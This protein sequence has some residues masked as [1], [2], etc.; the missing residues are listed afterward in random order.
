MGNAGTYLWTPHGKRT[1]DRG[2]QMCLLPCLNR[3]WWAHSPPLRVPLPRA[4]RGSLKPRKPR[5]TSAWGWGTDNRQRS[6]CC[7]WVFIAAFGRNYRSQRVLSI[8]KRS[9]KAIKPDKMI[10]F[11]FIRNSSLACRWRSS[12]AAASR[13]TRPCSSCR[14]WRQRAHA[15][16]NSS[17]D[18]GRGFGAL[19]APIP[20][21]LNDVIC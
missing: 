14:L 20:E 8:V 6:V 15:L 13:G 4:I 2:A 3:R 7:G 12:H 21:D 19:N 1:A 17:Y 10:F 16:F 5:L 9:G 11:S 18:V